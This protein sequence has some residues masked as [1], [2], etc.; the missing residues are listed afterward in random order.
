MSDLSMEAAIEGLQQ[1][2]GFHGQHADHPRSDWKYEVENDDTQLGYWEW[3]VHQ[4][5]A[6]G[7]DA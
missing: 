4:M 7:E 6:N 1:R 2:Y 3:L 5:E